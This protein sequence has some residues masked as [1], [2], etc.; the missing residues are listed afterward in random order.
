MPPS[1]Q[2]AVRLSAGKKVDAKGGASN[3]VHAR[4]SRTTV[5]SPSSWKHLH[6][7]IYM[8][9]SIAQDLDAAGRTRESNARGPPRGR[10]RSARS[11]QRCR[12]TEHQ[13]RAAHF[14]LTFLLPKMEASGGGARPPAEEREPEP[15]RETRSLRE[16]IYLVLGNNVHDGGV[17]GAA[18]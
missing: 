14:S 7:Y 2:P 17:Q 11:Q 13:E 6:G 10:E 16:M 15:E 18:R 4:A 9:T 3:C 1:C 5:R 8:R 12:H